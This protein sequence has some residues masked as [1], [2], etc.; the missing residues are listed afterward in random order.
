[1]TSETSH[2]D[3]IDIQSWLFWAPDGGDATVLIDDQKDRHSLSYSRLVVFNGVD[4]SAG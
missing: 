4:A 2:L 3:K 1:M